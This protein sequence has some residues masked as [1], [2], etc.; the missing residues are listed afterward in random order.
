MI[1]RSLNIH[2]SGM[3]GATWNCWWC[4]CIPPTAG[5]VIAFF[6]FWWCRCHTTD[7]RWRHRFFSSSFDGANDIPPTAGDVNA[8]FFFLLFFLCVCVDGA[9][10]VPPTAGDVI[11]FSPFLWLVQMTDTTDCRCKWR[12]APTA[13]FWWCKWQIPRVRHFDGSVYKEYK[14]AL[15][16]IICFWTSKW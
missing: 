2:Q 13:G 4:K 7:C 5:D 8:S 10:D 15:S 6:F 11:P 16:V 14:C 1:A 3:A 9:N 12:I